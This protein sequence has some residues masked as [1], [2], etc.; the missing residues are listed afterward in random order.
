MKWIKENWHNILLFL[1]A[2]LWTA[3]GIY[4]AVDVVIDNQDFN[5]WGQF[6][7]LFIFL[8]VSVFVV[9]SGF[10]TQLGLIKEFKDKK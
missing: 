2:S 9:Y 6:V 3:G 4:M 5:T 1:W 10:T 7:E 8:N